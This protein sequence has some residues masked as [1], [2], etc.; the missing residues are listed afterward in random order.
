MDKAH[1]EMKSRCSKEKED[2]RWVSL[3]LSRS[4]LLLPDYRWFAEE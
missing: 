3:I 4:I 1:R 2:L